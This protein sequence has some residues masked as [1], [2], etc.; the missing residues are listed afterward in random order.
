VVEEILVGGGIGFAHGALPR[1]L[2]I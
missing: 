1:C 2:D